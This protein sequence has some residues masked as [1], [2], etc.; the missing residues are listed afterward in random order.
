MS[1]E[2]LDL[3]M[4]PNQYVFLKKGIR[5]GLSMV[6]KRYSRANHPSLGPRFYSPHLPQK[7]ILYL[8][9][10][11]LYGKA[12]ME[13]L[14][15]SDFKWME[16]EEL[17]LDFICS[18]PD[19][20]EVGCIV[21]CNLSYPSDL[22]SSHADYPLAPDKC[23]ITYNQL[24]PVAKEI[25]DRH[26]L[27]G[28]T[29]TEKLMT[30]FHDKSSYVLHYRSLKLYVS[31]GLKVTAVN[32]GIKFKQSPLIRDYIQFNSDKRANAT[33]SFDTNYYKLLSNSLFGKTIERPENRVRVVL[34]TDPEKHQKLVGNTCY[35]ESKIINTN[36]VAATLGY[37]AVKVHKP[38]YIGVTI[39]EL[40]KVHMYNFHYNVMKKKF[41]DKLQ[42]LYT[43]TDSLLYEISDCDVYQ[44]LESLKEYFDFS[45]YPPSHKLYSPEGKRVPG[46][47]KDEASGQN[48]LEFVGL[49]SKMYS[50]ILAKSD[51]KFKET[52]TA[53]GVKKSIISRE[54]HHKDFFNC[55]MQQNQ[56][57]HSFHQIRSKSHSVTTNL[58]KKVTLSPFDDKRYLLDKINSLPHGSV[59]IPL[60][61]DC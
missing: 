5:G 8:D 51:G 31:L 32:L 52:K 42:L 58:Q 22:H 28:S 7:H 54:L 35:K 29:R 56:M 9:A 45:N 48:I 33:N 59:H 15:K 1:R 20:G 50:F 49:R 6:C 11:N 44:E 40:A 38:F 30:T 19:D 10:N 47:F 46:L 34:T 13:P 61:K 53:K 4:D 55:L 37:P 27:K 36:L 14:P 57:E 18:L 3:I 23:K 43:D 16:G 25:C 21:E 12:M 39:L 41:R 60:Q 26:N 24:S 17:T 2:K